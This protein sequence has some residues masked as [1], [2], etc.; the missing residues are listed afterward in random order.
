MHEFTFLY[1][2]FIKQV[3]SECKVNAN[4]FPFVKQVMS[5]CKIDTTNFPLDDQHC[6]LKFGSWT[7]NGLQLNLTMPTDSADLSFYTPNGE[8]EMVSAKATRDT[9]YFT[10][11]SAPYYTIT[12]TI[13]IRRRALFYVMNLILPCI[14]LT[15]LSAVTFR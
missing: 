2:T 15:L 4:E 1:F 11:C 6:Q 8:W 10:C 13:H 9:N 3:T 12:Y 14:L 5:E 7:Y